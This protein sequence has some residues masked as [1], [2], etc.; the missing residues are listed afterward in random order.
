[1]DHFFFVNRRG[2]DQRALVCVA[3]Q[4]AAS[5]AF[6]ARFHIDPTDPEFT[7][8][9]LVVSGYC[10]PTVIL[11]DPDVGHEQLTHRTYASQI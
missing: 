1:M 6:C 5:K 8:F 2:S 4:F 10:A 9:T 7:P 11:V 3:D